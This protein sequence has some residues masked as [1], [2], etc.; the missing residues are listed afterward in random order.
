MMI[1]QAENLPVAR[2]AAG[3]PNIS[4]LS[5]PARAFIICHLGNLGFLDKEKYPDSSPMQFA[6]DHYAIYAHFVQGNPK[7]RMLIVMHL[8]H[9]G[10]ILDGKGGGMRVGSVGIK[11]LQEQ[12]KE[13]GPLDVITYTSDERI[14]IDT[15]QITSID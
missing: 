14:M 9:P 11:R 13:K 7:R 4:F 3:V 12:I 8:D 5:L 15:N 2:E 6:Q 1:N 10:I